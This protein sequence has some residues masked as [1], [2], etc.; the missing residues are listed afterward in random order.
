MGILVLTCGS[1]VSRLGLVV[2][3]SCIQRGGGRR[4]RAG[5]GHPIPELLTSLNIN[6]GGP[7][8]DLEK[9]WNPDLGSGGGGVEPLPGS[10][11]GGEERFV[12]RCKVTV[13]TF[14]LL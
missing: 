1:Y 11:G 13:K 9:G 4:G 10:W 12:D 7:I 6:N 3:A 8:W 14:L 5:A 2:S